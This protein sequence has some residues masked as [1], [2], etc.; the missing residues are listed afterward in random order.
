MLGGFEIGEIG[1]RSQ[2]ACTG[3][4]GSKY[5]VLYCE[6][7]RSPSRQMEQAWRQGTLNEQIPDPLPPPSPKGW[8]L[9]L[10]SFAAAFLSFISR[11]SPEP[12][13]GPQQGNRKAMFPNF[14]R[15]PSS[16]LWPYRPPLEPSRQSERVSERVHRHTVGRPLDFLLLLPMNLPSTSGNC[17]NFKAADVR[18]IVPY[19]LGSSFRNSS[20]ILLSSSP[21]RFLFFRIP[22]QCFCLHCK[23]RDICRA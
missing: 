8:S 22:S 10:P 14:G 16:Y 3:S 23:P 21:I 7:G 4:A 17:H 13:I 15:L 2:W 19:L 18:H 1:L 5:G 9:F 6:K 11:P 20:L 12:A